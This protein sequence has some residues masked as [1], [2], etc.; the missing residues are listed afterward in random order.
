[1]DINLSKSVVLSAIA[2]SLFFAGCQTVDNINNKSVE[3]TQVA[4]VA[5]YDFT[6]QPD[7]CPK[8]TQDM[9]KQCS[10]QNGSM[11]RQGMAGC[12]TCTITYEDAGKTC[13]DKSDC[14]GDCKNYGEPIAMNVP[15]Q[16][17]QCASNNVVFGCYQTIK[18]GMATN[19][20]ICID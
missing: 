12:Y 11:Q 6:D 17:G 9:V 18:N 15:N 1:M 19:A 5:D 8:I 4:N 3:Q 14:L 16:T 10:Q 7:F 2:V 13:S 20:M